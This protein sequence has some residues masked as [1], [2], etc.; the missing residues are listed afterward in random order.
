[1]NDYIIIPITR[2]G[3]YA[4][5]YE[6]KISP[7]DDILLESNWYF[8]GLEK[9]Y[10]AKSI[11]VNGKKQMILMHRVIL[12]RKLGH[13]LG[14]GE[15]VDHIDGNTL[16]NQRHNLRIADKSKNGM[17]RGKTK[18]NKSGYKGISW[19]TQRGKW[20]VTIRKNWKQYHAGFFDDIELAKQARDKKGQELFGDFW[21]PG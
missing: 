2:T 21:N 14:A 16:N 18:A 8:S 3:K 1:M 11:Q 10:A 19:C 5:L 7:E 13:P 12:E 4:G 15:I 17:N 9:G 6:V 20:R